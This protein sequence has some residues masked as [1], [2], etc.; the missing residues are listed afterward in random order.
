M[1]EWIIYVGI[2]LQHWYCTKEQEHKICNICIANGKR[3]IYCWMFPIRRSDITKVSNRVNKS[4]G[5]DTTTDAPENSVITL[6]S[7]ISGDP[8][9]RDVTSAGK[10]TSFIIS[11]I[12]HHFS[13]GQAI[14]SLQTI[15]DT[16]HIDQLY[17]VT[18]TY[19]QHFHNL[20]QNENVLSRSCGMG[21][22]T[23]GQ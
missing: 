20:W 17:W 23:T 10:Y 6:L 5:I 12:C 14:W 4:Y 7:F 13:Y 19:S 8:G 1:H 16:F 2:S 9:L 3:A 18:H 15:L 22:G 21:M 11:M